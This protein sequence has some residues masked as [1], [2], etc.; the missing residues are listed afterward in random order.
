MALTNPARSV[1][2]AQIVAIAARD[3][4]RAQVFARK[5]RIRR[6][7]PTYRDLLV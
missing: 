4:K 7:H 3:P 1:P 6:V 5:H 2:E